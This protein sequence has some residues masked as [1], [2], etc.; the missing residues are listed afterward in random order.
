MNSENSP[1]W[2]LDAKK[3]LAFFI[4]IMGDEEC[5]GSEFSDSYPA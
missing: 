3:C 2:L 4:E 5:M 1:Q